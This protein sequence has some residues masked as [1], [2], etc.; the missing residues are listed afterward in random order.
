M[1]FW[2]R[3]WQVT[4]LAWMAGTSHGL[5]ALQ[6]EL[7]EYLEFFSASGQQRSRLA[8]IRDLER[9][10]ENILAPRET[11]GERGVHVELGPS[12]W[13]TGRWA[14]IELSPRLER[15]AASDT[16]VLRVKMS[17]RHT[18]VASA[19]TFSWLSR[20]HELRLSD[21]SFNPEILETLKRT[22]AQ[23][24]AASNYSRQDDHVEIVVTDR[25]GRERRIERIRGQLP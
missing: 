2:L 3:R 1:Y 11:R 13:L 21:L 24:A 4:C 8:K 23:A 22:Q 5:N 14:E 19:E 17:Q 10:L 20:R 15:G 9:V 18:F 7:D 16:N 25:E 12:I 6:P